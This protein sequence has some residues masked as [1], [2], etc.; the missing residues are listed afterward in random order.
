MR[1]ERGVRESG[2]A[3]K[4]KGKGRK[5]VHEDRKDTV[6]LKHRI[7]SVEKVK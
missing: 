1:S 5:K 2:R 7:Y 6:R 3:K 4:G